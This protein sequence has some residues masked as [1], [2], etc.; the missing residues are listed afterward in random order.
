MILEI[1][2]DDKIFTKSITLSITICPLSLTILANLP[3]FWRFFCSILMLFY[4]V[5]TLLLLLKKNFALVDS[6]IAVG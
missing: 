4:S 3:S 2:M 6:E 1:V 5:S